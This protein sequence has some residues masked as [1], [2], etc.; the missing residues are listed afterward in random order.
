LSTLAPFA[1]TGVSPIRPTHREP[2][3]S[4]SARLAGDPRQVIAQKMEQAGQ[5]EAA[6]RTFLHYYDQLRSGADGLLTSGQAQPVQ[7][8]PIAEDFD[9]Y[10]AM[11]LGALKRTALVKLNGGLGTTMGMQGPKSLIQVKNALTFLDIIVRQTL[12]LRKEHGVELPLILM[13]SFNT[14]HQTQL[15]LNAY[16]NLRQRLPHSFVQHKVPKIWTENFHP[17]EWPSERAKEWCPPGHGDLY[18]ALQTSGML[19]QLLAQGYEYAFISNAD[20]LGATLDLN[21]LGYFVRER[22]PFLME[23][24]RRQAV[25]SK[26]G[27]LAQQPGQ[28]LIL[29]ELAQCPQAELAEFQDIDRY[30]YFNTNNLWLHLPKLQQILTERDGLLGL[31]LINNE[32]PV[33]PAQPGSPRVYQLETAMGHAISLFPGAQAI[34]IQRGRFLPVKSTNDLLALWSDAYVLNRDF[35]ISPNPARNAKEALVIDLDK[36]YYG[37]FHQLKARFP[38][39]VPS[40]VNCRQFR[41]RG[42]VYF[43]ADLALE[44]DVCI[45]QVGEKPVRWATVP[46]NEL[47]HSIE[48][49]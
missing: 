3:W 36:T 16:P 15:A 13:N 23:V 27:H 43:D 44:G 19:D 30:C 10:H 11:G 2:P 46:I 45:Q 4:P 12:S 35:T 18:L 41:V 6:I 1:P 32:K 31:P 40:L 28:G 33:D 48:H 7:Q 49:A 26:G 14:D 38:Y 34:E 17:V 37:F 29:R 24:A 39:H 20:N 21:I 8:L 25:D 42:N 9:R 47:G 22:L 5:H